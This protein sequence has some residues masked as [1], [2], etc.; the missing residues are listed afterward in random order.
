LR[1]NVPAITAALLFGEEIGLRPMMSLTRI[2]VINGRVLR[3]WN[4]STWQ[5]DSTVVAES[6]V[7]SVSVQDTHLPAGSQ[8]LVANTF[9]E[10]AVDLT[11]S[12]LATG[13]GFSHATAFLKS[14]SSASFTSEVK[15]FVAPISTPIAP[16]GTQITT[17]L[18][19]NPVLVGYTVTDSATISGATSDAGGTVTY[20][21]YSDSTCTTF[22]ADA[23][24]VTVTNGIVPDSNPVTFND[25]GTFYWQA[26]YSGDPPANEGCTSD[27]LS[28]ALVV[29]TVASSMTSAQ[30]FIP[31]DSATISAPPAATWRAASRSTRTRAATARAP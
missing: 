14:R 10:V 12:G 25:P 6:A 17:S 19:A 11:A 3:T 15:D 31:N 16:C 24:T 28:E 7:N 27:S 4:G 22:S 8:T 29:N 2:A 20:T 21:V 13:C 30:S 5:P 26:V 18:S 9:G 1:N 23:G